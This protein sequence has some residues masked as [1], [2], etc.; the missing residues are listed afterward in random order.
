MF[1]FK[2]PDGNTGILFTHYAYLYPELQ[3][4]HPALKNA[5]VITESAVELR[6]TDV[7]M[8]EVIVTVPL[9]AEDMIEE[10]LTVI[11]AYNDS[12]TAEQN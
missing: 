11:E 4:V 9:K 12:G 8:N 7:P 1:Y 10:I 3:A 5:T 6:D 2:F